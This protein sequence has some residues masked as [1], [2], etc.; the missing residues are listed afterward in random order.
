[1]G[2]TRQPDFGE[3]EEAS[4]KLVWIPLWNDNDDAR[5]VF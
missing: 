1:M 3:D 5:S 4:D 2:A